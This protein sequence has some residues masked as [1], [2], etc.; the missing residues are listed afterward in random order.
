MSCRRLA[1]ILAGQN[2]HQLSDDQSQVC[3]GPGTVLTELGGAA[4][5]SVAE[6]LTDAV[7]LRWEREKLTRSRHSNRR[8]GQDCFPDKQTRTLPESRSELTFCRA[9]DL[10]LD[11]VQTIG[12]PSHRLGAIR[13]WHRRGCVR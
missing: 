1:G 3:S 12:S 11:A 5:L 6:G 8:A 10:K 2:R 4:I 9:N 7:S 13:P